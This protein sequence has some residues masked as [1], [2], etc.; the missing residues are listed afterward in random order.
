[1]HG[2]AYGARSA[3]GQRHGARSRPCWPHGASAQGGPGNDEGPSTHELEGP[4]RSCAADRRSLGARRHRTVRRT[5]FP[6]DRSAGRAVRRACRPLPVRSL[7]RRAAPRRCV[8]RFPPDRSAGAP[9][10]TSRPVRLPSDRSVDAPRAAVPGPLTVRLL[11]RRAS[12]HVCLVRCLPIARQVASRHA[13]VS[14]R[15]IAR[16]SE[17]RNPSSVLVDPS[18]AVVSHRFRRPGVPSGAVPVAGDVRR[19]LV[20]GRQ[21]PQGVSGTDSDDFRGPQRSP[22]VGTRCAPA[23]T[24]CPPV[25]PRSSTAAS[26]GGRRACPA[27]GLAAA[28]DADRR[29]VLRGDDVPR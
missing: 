7:G 26:T 18:A 13:P 25:E 5:R 2:P 29:R 23:S 21:P 11:G 1:M 10:R 4:R 6:T 27:C 9:R 12:W 15:T 19:F 24:G 22:Q 28:G 20:P 8:V 17:P 14:W 16:P 3:A